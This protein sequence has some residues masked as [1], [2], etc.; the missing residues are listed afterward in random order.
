MTSSA[1]QVEGFL[2]RYGWMFDRVS[3]SQWITG[4][5]GRY[6]TF[7]LSI[8]LSTTM[9]CFKVEPLFHTTMDW[10]SRADLLKYLCEINAH[11]PMV[12]LVIEEDGDISLVLQLWSRHLRYKDFEHAL[13]LIGYYADMLY[14][15]LTIKL[16][17][18]AE[19]YGTTAHLRLLT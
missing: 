14:E 13:G 2:R 7:S 12:K 9:V 8:G 11:T 15:D 17:E 18:N 16:R 19:A 4:W 3:N 1:E 5:Q 6:C 10:D